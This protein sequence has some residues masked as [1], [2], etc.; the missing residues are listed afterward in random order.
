MKARV[1][2]HIPKGNDD[3][4]EEEEEIFVLINFSSGH[5]TDFLIC[6]LCSQEGLY[7]F[8]SAHLFSKDAKS[9]SGTLYLFGA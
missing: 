3:E 6:F 1:W 5:D 9:I 8:P 7:F 2:V 4:E